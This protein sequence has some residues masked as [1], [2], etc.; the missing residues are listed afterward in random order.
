MG[1]YLEESIAA[2]CWEKV[3]TGRVITNCWHSIHMAFPNNDY[4]QALKKVLTHGKSC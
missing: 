4:E 3:W 1:N 2:D